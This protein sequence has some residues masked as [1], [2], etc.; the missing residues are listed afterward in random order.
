MVPRH[1]ERLQGGFSQLQKRNEDRYM[2]DDSE[3]FLKRLR[4]KIRGKNGTQYV[5]WKI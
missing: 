1:E 4:G 2:R 3:M 5:I